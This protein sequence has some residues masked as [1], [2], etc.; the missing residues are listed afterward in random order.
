[1]GLVFKYLLGRVSGERANVADIV[2]DLCEE[3]GLQ[4]SQIDVSR[5]TDTTLGFIRTDLVEARAPIEILMTCYFF[6]KVESDGKIQFIPRNPTPAKTPLAIPEGD[7]GAYEYGGTP[8]PKLGRNRRLETEFP[9]EVDVQYLNPGKKYEQGNQRDRRLVTVSQLVKTF[10]FAG[11]VLTNTE[12]KKKA[13][14]LMAALWLERFP[15][16]LSLPKKYIGQNPTDILEVSVDA[17]TH[18]I[19]IQKMDY[20]APGLLKI[21]GI[22]EDFAAYDPDASADEDDDDDEITVAGPTLMHLLDVPILRDGDDD[23]GFYAAACG[24]IDGWRGSILYVSSD[25]GSSYSELLAMLYAADIGRSETV[26]A[27]GPTTV[28]DNTN[29][30]TIR[31]VSGT[32]ESVSKLNVLNGKNAG[33][34]GDEVIQWQTATLVSAGVY[35]LSGLLRGR[36]G[37]DCAIDTHRIGERFVVISPSTMERIHSQVDLIGLNRKYKAVTVGGKLSQSPAI[38]F[39]NTAAGL[40]PYSPVHVTGS[41]DGGN[42]LTISWVRRTRI[43]GA[44]RD[45]VDASIGE[46]SEAYE[47]DILDGSNVIRT[48]T[49]LSSA[50]ADYPAVQQSA[51]G[52]TPGDPIDC[53]VYQISETIGRGYGRAATV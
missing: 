17:F 42:N 51:D 48:I 19:R 7:L 36:R 23:S 34:L 2:S 14:A 41:R 8:P 3:S 15:Y 13:R 52:L 9:I 46:A 45:Y 30:V 18:T 44:W 24:L 22:S 33:I 35:E 6:D 40:M 49:G 27:S 10:A 28:F 43:G 11:L 32:L 29:T 20:G 5:I 26:L 39:T 31:M 50:S 21:E 16:Q 53:I 25:G 4:A 38:N 12:A 1:M 37:T 47:V